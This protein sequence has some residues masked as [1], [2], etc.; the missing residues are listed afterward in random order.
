MLYNNALEKKENESKPDPSSE[1]MDDPRQ[2]VFYR[3][4]PVIIY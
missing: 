3:V 4:R 2:I 1:D